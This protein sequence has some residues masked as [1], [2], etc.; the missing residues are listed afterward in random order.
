[1]SLWTELLHLFQKLTQMSHSTIGSQVTH[2]FYSCKNE[3]TKK[4]NQLS[5]RRIIHKNKVK[6]PENMLRVHNRERHNIGL[7]Y[8]EEKQNSTD[9]INIIPGW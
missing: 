4:K 1:M 5:S 7:L 2:W 8:D 3:Q 9:T 6:I